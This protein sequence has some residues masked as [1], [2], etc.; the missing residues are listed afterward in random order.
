MYSYSVIYLY[1][2]LPRGGNVRAG[3]LSVVKEGSE[4]VVR[5]FCDETQGFVPAN[6]SFPEMR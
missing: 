5:A 4:I 2:T 3:S 6:G 1:P